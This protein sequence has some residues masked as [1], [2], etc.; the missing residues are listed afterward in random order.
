MRSHKKL[1][2]KREADAIGKVKLQSNE[3]KIE[4]IIIHALYY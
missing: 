3:R 2:N 4:M 1:W